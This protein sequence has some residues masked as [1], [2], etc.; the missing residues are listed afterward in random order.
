MRSALL[1]RSL[2][3]AFL[4]TMLA[5]FLSALA[6]TP[7]DWEDGAPAFMV[8]WFGGR[9]ELSEELLPVRSIRD[10]AE[11]AINPSLCPI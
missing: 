9:T 4:R 6:A 1:S 8:A 3:I 11:C 7:R 5:W 10:L 2:P